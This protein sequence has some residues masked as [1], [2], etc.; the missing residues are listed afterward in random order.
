MDILTTDDKKSAHS[1]RR[2][3][4][5]AVILRAYETVLQRDGVRAVGVNSVV[6]E[7]GVGKGLIY[8]YFGGLPGIVRAWVARTRLWP[9]YL[10]IRTLAHPI[11]WALI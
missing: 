2:K 10:A 9:D 1:E 6:K 7:A 3:A 11:A 8:K 4:T 5:G